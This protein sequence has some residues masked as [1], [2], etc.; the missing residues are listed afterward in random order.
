MG[1]SNNI[2][3]PFVRTS[4]LAQS[5]GE[6]VAGLR[7]RAG[8][9]ERP[10]VEQL[11][12][13]QMLFSLTISADSVDP[14]TGLGSA[15]AF[16]HYYV[17]YLATTQTFTDVPAQTQTEGFDQENYGPIG[18]G[19]V[20][21]QSGLEFRHNVNPAGDIRVAANPAT[22]DNNARYV[23]VDLNETG[24]YFALRFR[25]DGTDPQAPRIAVRSCSFAV[26]GDPV[27]VGGDNTGLLFNFLRADLYL[28]NQVIASYTGNQLRA[29]VVDGTPGG[30]PTGVGNFRVQAPAAT[31]AFDEL[32]FTMLTPPAPG[33]VRTPF[34]IDDVSFDRTPNKYGGL[35]DSRAFGAAVALTGPVG[36]TVSFFDLYG[37][38][39][40][41]TLAG[42]PAGNSQVSPGD[43]DD[44]GV[45]DRN[46]GIG[47]IRFSGTDSR[48]SFIMLG[49]ELGTA[50]ERPDAF[51]ANA[52]IPRVFWDGAYTLTLKDDLKGLY[53]DFETAGFGFAADR[54]NTQVVITG[55]PPGSGSVV[56]GSPFV[57]DNA[58]AQ[59][60]NPEGF[61]QQNGQAIR[62]VT[63]GFTRTDQGFFLEDGSSIGSVTVN[64]MV[65]GASKFNGFGDRFSVG[66]LTGTLTVAGDLGS[67][68]VAADA[69]IWSPDPNFAFQDGTPIDQNNKTNALAV[70]GRTVGQVLIGGRSQLDVTVVGDL[71]SPSTKPQRDSS[72]YYE[73]EAYSGAAPG[74]GK[75]VGLSQAASNVTLNAQTSSNLGRTGGQPVV[76]GDNFFRND[77]ILSA[78]IINSQSA[79]VR[80]K[81]ELSQQDPFNGEDEADVYGFAVT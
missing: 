35:M 44:N 2:N 36:A 6:G 58:S 54:R 14:N 8:M 46:D 60:Y 19:R 55:M 69:G 24:E 72:V 52:L 7:A 73:L 68:V 22:Q 10:S 81:G 5:K 28:N 48:T 59:T 56:V 21:A 49:G 64:G 79:G 65:F 37:R 39:M 1:R 45:P 13:R 63:T 9:T 3:R 4:R 57:R 50:T 43:L 40:L 80:I 74:A 61:A 26:A 12:R 71:S 38:D 78:E 75:A 62:T 16:F 51:D 20:F 34:V 47:R 25:A 32:R 30:S 77:S 76:F 23:R 66:N 33:S 42:I 53:D 27:T 70:V 29:L 67:L 11:E 15:N 41:G 31:P 17:P 18:S